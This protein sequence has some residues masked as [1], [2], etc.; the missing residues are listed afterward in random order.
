MT[1]INLVVS[2]YL[3]RRITADSFWH[4]SNFIWCFFGNQGFGTWPSPQFFI[5]YWS[6]WFWL[7]YSTTK[8]FFH[9]WRVWTNDLSD[10][11]VSYSLTGTFYMCPAQM[12]LGGGEGAERRLFT[13]NKLVIILDLKHQKHISL[14]K[15]LEFLY[16]QRYELHTLPISASKLKT[17]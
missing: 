15:Y 2:Y 9:S 14:R 12:G 16:K 8:L 4:I 17:V 1:S 13:M 7:L 5:F 10:E 11:C 3:A 6:M